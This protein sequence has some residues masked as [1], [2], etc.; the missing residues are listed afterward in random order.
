MS[1]PYSHGCARMSLKSALNPN[2]FEESAFSNY[3]MN[4]TQFFEMSMS[5][6]RWSY[7]VSE[8]SM[9]ISGEV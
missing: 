4:L 1:T 6:G 5:R 9:V 2:R 8:S 7:C 3:A